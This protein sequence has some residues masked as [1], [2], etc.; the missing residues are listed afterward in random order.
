MIKKVKAVVVFP[1]FIDL[2]IDST[3]TIDQIEE[4]VID[5]ANKAFEISTIK[6]L[7]N[8]MEFSKEIEKV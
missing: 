3:L 7:I 4:L 2:D 6:P 1:V 5:N 8:S